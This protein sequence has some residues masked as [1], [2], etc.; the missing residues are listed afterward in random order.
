[1]L[2]SLLAR[3][4]RAG[5]PTWLIAAV[6]IRDG[7]ADT[8][9]VSIFLA[10]VKECRCGWMLECSCT[11]HKAGEMDWV[12]IHIKRLFTVRRE[13]REPPKR[14]L[15]KSPTLQTNPCVGGSGHTPSKPTLALGSDD[16]P[17]KHKRAYVAQLCFTPFEPCS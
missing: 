17:C 15:A 4:L 5:L 16:P 8:L 9:L 1:M 10:A 14:N 13:E 2:A 11:C 3:A 12:E 6:D 7:S